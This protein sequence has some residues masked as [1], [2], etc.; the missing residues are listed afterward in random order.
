VI[1]FIYTSN[2]ER[3]GRKIFHPFQNVRCF[4]S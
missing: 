1:K 4:G 2:E 3:E